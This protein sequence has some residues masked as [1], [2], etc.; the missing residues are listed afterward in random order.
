MRPKY[1]H[2]RVLRNSKHHVY[3]LSSLTLGLQE[4]SY[5]PLQMDG[6]LKTP[7]KAPFYYIPSYSSTGNAKYASARYNSCYVVK[8][9]EV[10]GKIVEEC[11][12]TDAQKDRQP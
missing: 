6:N 7:I 4:V 8:K 1:K 12:H 2:A 11:F 3:T 5:L 10:D 9:Q